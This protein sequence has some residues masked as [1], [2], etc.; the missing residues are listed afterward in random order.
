MQIR[1]A[2]MDQMFNIML[3]VRHQ[4]HVLERMKRHQGHISE[5]MT[6]DISLQLEK[7]MALRQAYR[8][9]HPD[10]NFSNAS[11]S[12][13]MHRSGWFSRK[14]SFYSPT[15]YHKRKYGN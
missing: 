3:T 8:E 1:E 15:G 4:R 13:N 11:P 9:D 6:R 14:F 10:L 2:Q 12:F 7:L 5:C